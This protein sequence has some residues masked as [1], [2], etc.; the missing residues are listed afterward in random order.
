MSSLREMGVA[1]EV[2]SLVDMFRS[3]FS[4]RTIRPPQAQAP[5]DRA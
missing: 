5:C 2:D 4:H 3:L 1:A